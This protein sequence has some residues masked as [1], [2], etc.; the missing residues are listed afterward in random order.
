MNIRLL[1]D[2]RVYT[3]RSRRYACIIIYFAP[4]T[5]SLADRTPPY[6]II[7]NSLYVFR[8]ILYII[9][10]YLLY[11]CRVPRIKCVR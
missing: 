11:E 3:H 4:F 8:F 5:E 10:R 9:I 1:D 7:Y 2:L 6:I